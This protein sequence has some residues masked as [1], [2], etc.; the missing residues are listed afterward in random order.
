[1]FKEM[2]TIYIDVNNLYMPTRHYL[3]E[4]PNRNGKP[5]SPADLINV[6]QGRWRIYVCFVC[7][8]QLFHFLWFF[9]FLRRGGGGFV[10]TS[11][12]GEGLAIH[13]LCRLLMLLHD[14]YLIIWRIVSMCLWCTTVFFFFSVSFL[15][16]LS[17]TWPNRSLSLYVHW[18]DQL[19]L[20][21]NN[22]KRKT[23]K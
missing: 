3:L 13:F 14:Q 12:C 2:R 18:Q 1:M 9:F 17:L 11:R 19:C 23:R 16:S 20:K 8:F 10:L 7:F 22:E 21:S 5:I 15:S 4:R 6:S